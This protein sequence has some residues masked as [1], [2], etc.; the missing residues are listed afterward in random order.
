MLLSESPLLSSWSRLL[1]F[2]DLNLPSRGFFLAEVECSSSFL[3]SSLLLVS[4]EFSPSI[5]Q[6]ETK[7]SEVEGMERSVGD[8]VVSSQLTRGRFRIRLLD[9]LDD[10]RF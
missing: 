10:D 9:F 2:F 7:L 5:E 1:L 8:G 6:L 4:A 3:A